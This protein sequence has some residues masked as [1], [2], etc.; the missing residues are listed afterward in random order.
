[1]PAEVLAVQFLTVAHPWSALDGCSSAQAMNQRDGVINRS[2][3]ET[4]AAGG[5]LRNLGRE[6]FDEIFSCSTTCPDLKS[7][8]RLDCTLVT[9]LQSRQMLADSKAVAKWRNGIEQARLAL[10]PSAHKE[11][12]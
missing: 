3:S 1:M 10:S 5:D 11:D 12:L 8:F 6:P 4:A 9:K 7:T 2:V